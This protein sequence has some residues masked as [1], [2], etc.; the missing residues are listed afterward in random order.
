MQNKTKGA[1]TPTKTMMEET[2][3]SI[4]DMLGAK[5]AEYE[6]NVVAWKAGGEIPAFLVR[7]YPLAMTALLRT[8][9]SH[10]W[11][12]ILSKVLRILSSPTKLDHWI[13]IAAYATLVANDIRELEARK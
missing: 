2:I 5:G 9:Y 4:S 3:E 7:R 6:G 1:V 12:I 11:F 10:N 13:D 8:S